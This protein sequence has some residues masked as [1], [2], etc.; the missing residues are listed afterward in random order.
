MHGMYIHV[1]TNTQ[2][3]CIHQ[4]VCVCGAV[5]LVTCSTKS[6]NTLSLHTRQLQ[7]ALPFTYYNHSYTLYIPHTHRHTHTHTPSLPRSLPL[8]LSL[9]WN[10]CLNRGMLLHAYNMIGS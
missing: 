8:P 7:T 5:V 3:T 6:M 9:Q 1:Q 10:A 2:Y 4:S